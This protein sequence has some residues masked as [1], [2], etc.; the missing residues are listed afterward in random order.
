MISYLESLV[1]LGPQ[2]GIN[3][4]FQEFFEF[5]VPSDVSMGEFVMIPPEVQLRIFEFLD[6]DTLGRVSQTC[7]YWHRMGSADSLWKPLAQSRFVF[8]KHPLVY[9][10]WKEQFKALLAKSKQPYHVHQPFVVI[11]SFHFVVNARL[12]QYSYADNILDRHHFHPWT[13]IKG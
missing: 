3:Q 5:I 13:I 10:T 11:I 8:D 1:A 9:E 6:Y 2:V 7:K 12:V 4:H